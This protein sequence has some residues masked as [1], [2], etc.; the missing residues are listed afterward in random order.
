[1][2][3]VIVI[4]GQIGPWQYSKQFVREMLKDEKGPVEVQ[5]SSLGGSV[6]HALDIH[7]QFASHGDIHVCF[8]GM[9]ASSATLIS[10]SAKSIKMSAY[11][12][13]LIHKPLNWVDEFGRMNEDDIEATIQKLIKQKNELAKITLVIAQMYMQRTGMA[14]QDVLNLM[15]EEIWLTAEEAKEKGFIDE[16]FTPSTVVNYLEDSTRMAM[17]EASGYPVPGR[18]KPISEPPSQTQSEDSLATK[19]VSQIKQFFSPPTNSNSPTPMKKQFLL[20]N[21]AIAVAQL[22]STSEGVFLSEAQLEAIESSLSNLAALETAR[23][24]AENSLSTAI[25][26]LD[27]LD[28]SVKEAADITAKLAAITTLLAAKPGQ[29]P[30]GITTTKD[31]QTPSADGVN[32]EVLNALPHMQTEV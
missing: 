25:A 3:K 10:L 14:I 29:K 11:S 15:K 16:V 31:P 9:N 26:S 18:A 27:Q 20:V 12:F 30:A 13:Y 28:P 22:E 23:T 21:K 8:T 2:A 7:Q 4:D 24:T 32:W 19:I 6:D 1:M 17:L 5:I